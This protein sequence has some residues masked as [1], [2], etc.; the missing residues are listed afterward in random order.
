MAGESM[1]TVVEIS[2]PVRLNVAAHPGAEATEIARVLREKGL[3]LAWRA[4]C[5]EFTYDGTEPK[6][7]RRWDYNKGHY[8]G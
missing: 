6:L 3:P 1:A 4:V 7:F 2:W 5:S 8:R